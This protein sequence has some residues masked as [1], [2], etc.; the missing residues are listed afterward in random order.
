M[1]SETALFICLWA[2][3]ALCAVAAGSEN[4]NFVLGWL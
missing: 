4:S 3:I 1:S 2:L